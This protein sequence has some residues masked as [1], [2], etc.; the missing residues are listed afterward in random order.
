MHFRLRP[1]YIIEH[2][3]DINVDE[4]KDEGIKALIFDLDNTLMTPKACEFCEEISEWINLIQNDFKI[5]IL[6]NNSDSKYIDKVQKIANF[7]VYG[8][9]KKPFRKVAL[10]VIKELDVLPSQ[11]AM[12]GDRP[13]TDI[14]VGIRLGMMTILVD[15]LLKNEENK[16]FQVLRKIERIITIKKP[17][18]KFSKRK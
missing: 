8:S 16:L 4:L 10:K 12:I 7:P 11:C 6:S 15:P 13:L 2:V 1:S 14:L 18:K 9:A 3:R 17:E 5:A